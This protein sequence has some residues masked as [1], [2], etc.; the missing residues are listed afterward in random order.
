MRQLQYT[1]QFFDILESA[2]SLPK[3]TVKKVLDILD[4]ENQYL[5]TERGNN[6]RLAHHVKEYINDFEFVN[7]EKHLIKHLQELGENLV[8][9]TRR[10]K[11][12]LTG[13][14]EIN[15]THYVG[16][17]LNFI[18]AQKIYSFDLDVDFR[19]LATRA[20]SRYD[21]PYDMLYM[22]FKGK[23]NSINSMLISENG[24]VLDSL[25]KIVSS[26]IN[27][28]KENVEKQV[29]EETI[30]ILVD[31]TGNRYI[32]KEN[33]QKLG[34]PYPNDYLWL[35][36]EQYYAIVKIHTIK[37]EN[38]K[39]PNETAMTEKGKND[40]PPLDFLTLDIFTD[41]T[42]K[43]ITWTVAIKLGLV[44]SDDQPSQYFCLTDKMY[45]S[46]KTKYFIDIISLPK[47]EQS[48][49]PPKLTSDENPR[50]VVMLY[51]S[52]ENDIY[53]NVPFKGDKIDVE[54]I[55]SPLE[56]DKLAD[57]LSE[58]GICFI[59]FDEQGQMSTAKK[60]EM[61]PVLDSKFEKIC[62]VTLVSNTNGIEYYNISYIL[63][64]GSL[65]TAPI[66]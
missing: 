21:I 59:K 25:S 33:A 43:Y 28:L 52:Q 14:G 4:I 22:F 1:K 20:S 50:P 58:A 23:T 35:T 34:W 46:I 51:V 5:S 24:K 29:A 7:I 44:T 66:I 42:K 18:K 17:M 37:I 12:E 47:K 49:T 26:L 13:T 31:E 15:I 10:M 60:D 11:S 6:M 32:D 16:E 41:G 3:D 39:K 54:N 8:N 65:S 19:R 53:L 64:D 27:E 55:D 30:T 38:F 40:N 56:L 2:K 45:E 36:I 62:T 9:I 48:V 61:S 63:K 57:V